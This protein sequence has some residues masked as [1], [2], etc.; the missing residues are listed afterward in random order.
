MEFLWRWQTETGAI[1]ISPLPANITSIIKPSMAMRPFF[2][3]E[4][5]LLDDKVVFI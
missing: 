3:I 1:S 4:T 5:A 2:G